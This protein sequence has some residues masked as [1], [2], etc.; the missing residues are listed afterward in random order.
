MLPVI[1]ILAHLPASAL[2][3]EECGNPRGKFTNIGFAYE[4]VNQSNYPKL[5]SDYGVNFSK[6]T[7]YYLHKP[8]AGMLRFGI[9]AVWADVNYA[10]YKVH[11]I[12]SS[13]TVHDAEF[14][15]HSVNLGMHVGPSATV[16]L[17]KRLQAQTYFRYNPS[18][19]LLV[20]DG[21]VQAGF[22]NMFVGGFAV[23]Y[24]FIGLGIEARFGSTKAK[25][26]V[27]A[28]DHIGDDDNNYEEW[29]PESSGSKKVKTK[30]SGF[31]T[32]ISFRF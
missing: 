18:L 30:F 21:E 9:D 4:K 29:T 16:N 11:E 8:I 31:R 7:T 24:G 32:F 13:P 17:F 5:H 1:L 26:Y 27:D 15:I 14:S 20:N 2:T 12:F 25:T 23:N 28:Y 10:N 19:S 22:A 3:P 6:G